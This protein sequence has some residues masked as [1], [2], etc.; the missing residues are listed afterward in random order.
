MIEFLNGYKKYPK[1][2][3][4]VYLGYSKIK[5]SVDFLNLTKELRNI[6]NR[7]FNQYKD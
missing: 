2:L 6:F 4:L 5:L 3:K 7:I 1:L